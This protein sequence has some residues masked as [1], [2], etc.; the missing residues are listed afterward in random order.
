MIFVHYTKLLAFVLALPNLS[1]FCSCKLSAFILNAYF[2][3]TVETFF[4]LKC[5]Y[6]LGFGLK[7]AMPV[8]ETKDLRLCLGVLVHAVDSLLVL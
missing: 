2:K 8:E 1:F 3:R 5:Q 6:S 7:L 4:S